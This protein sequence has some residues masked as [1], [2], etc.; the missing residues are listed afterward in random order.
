MKKKYV[1]AD[2]FEINAPKSVWVTGLD[3]SCSG[4]F[5]PEIEAGYTFRTDLLR[6]VLAW[7]EFAP[8]G[9][10][11]FLTGPTGS[12]KSSLIL[13]IAA[14]LNW[15]V[16]R[17]TGHARLEFSDLV[18][19]PVIQTD[20]SMAFEYGP[21]AHSMKEGSLFLIDEMD[22]LDPGV[23][24][25]FNGIVQ[26]E[27]LTIPENGGEVIKQHP[28]FRIVTTGNTTGNGD[29]GFYHGVFRQN[30]AFMDRFWIVHVDY[31]GEED[32]EKILQSAICLT[33]DAIKQFVRAA[34]EIRRLFVEGAIEITLST[35]VLLRWA[36]LTQFFYA[37]SKNDQSPVHYALDRALLFRAEP[38]TREAVHEVVQR[39][40][41]E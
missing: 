32:E 38:E 12:G 18:G 4:D 40:F 14:R 17:I 35:R 7:W 11:L 23:A 1:I 30:E 36:R 9:D 6:D 33:G 29:E 39:I 27:P 24:A 19:R 3:E 16:R 28:D 5:T 21:L 15:P 34:G 26:G 10:G 20:G 22:M 25:G 13:Q 37:V 8:Q 31:P 41:G 2:I